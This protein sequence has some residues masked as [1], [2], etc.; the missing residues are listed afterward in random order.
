MD[1]VQVHGNFVTEFTRSDIE[2]N[3][4]VSSVFNFGRLNATLEIS[5]TKEDERIFNVSPGLIWNHFEALNLAW[6]STRV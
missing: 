5:G 2:F 4:G 3:Y 6:Q 1:K